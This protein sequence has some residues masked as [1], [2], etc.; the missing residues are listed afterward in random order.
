MLIFAELGAG[1]W[2]MLNMYTVTRQQRERFR[3][4]RKLTHLGV[5]VQQVFHHVHHEIVC[6]RPE[7]TTLSIFAR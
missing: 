2:N 6:L 7:D 3:D 4:H 1:Q 5:G